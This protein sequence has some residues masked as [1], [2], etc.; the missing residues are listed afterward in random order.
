[1]KKL[2]FSIFSTI[3]FLGCSDS[4]SNSPA[5]SELTAL[6]LMNVQ[7]GDDPEQIMDVY[8]PA[9]RNSDT[10][11]FILVHGGG[12]SGG[13][14]SEFTPTIPI[15]KQEFPDYAIVN[16][17]YRLATAQSPAF[18][19]QID[20][21]K[22][23]IQFVKNSDYNVSRKFAFIGVSAGAH[24]SMFYSYK[25]DSANEVKAVASIVGPTDFTDPAYTSDPQYGYAALFLLG[26]EYI[27]NPTIIEEV[28][29]A[30]QVKTTS[31]PTAMFYGGQD[32]LIPVSQPQRL[33]A[34]LDQ[35]NVYNEYYL[36]PEGGHGNWDAETSVDFLA[37]LI[38]FF[39]NKF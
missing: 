36:Y 35:K 28:S 21:I 4:E 39:N 34:K 7:Y 37:K 6:D 38:A 2:L 3:L 24:L 26:D 5:P 14:K 30:L 31:P 1:M 15:L 23:V 29:P 25:Y 33:K 13:S 9:N 19:K 18:P 12:W 20:D 8:L 17:D 27:N 10:K 32:P 11:V 16:I 22:K